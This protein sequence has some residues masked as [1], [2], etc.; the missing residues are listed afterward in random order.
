MKFSFREPRFSLAQ[1]PINVI[2]TRFCF[3][4]KSSF[5]TDSSQFAKV[6]VFSAPWAQSGHNDF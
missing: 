3:V 5:A 2:E 4:Q 6:S 1:L